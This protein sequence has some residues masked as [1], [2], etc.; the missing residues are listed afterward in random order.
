MSRTVVRSMEHKRNDAN[1]DAILV[2]LFVGFVLLN[3]GAA[4]GL[5]HLLG[6]PAGGSFLLSALP[7]FGLGATALAVAIA[8]FAVMRRCSIASVLVSLGLVAVAAS[9]AWLWVLCVSSV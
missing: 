6:Y 5:P 4:F 9:N 8:G 7:G 2:S 3:A 1:I